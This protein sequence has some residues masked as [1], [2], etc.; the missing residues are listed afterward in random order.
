VDFDPSLTGK[1]KR[2]CSE[3]HELGHMTKYCQDSPTTSQKS[4]RLSSTQG[5]GSNDPSVAHTSQ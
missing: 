1:K 2:E 5:E 4:M 3:C